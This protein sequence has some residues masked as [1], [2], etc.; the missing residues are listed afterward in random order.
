MRTERN[1]QEGLFRFFYAITMTADCLLSLG[2]NLGARQDQLR[3]AVERLA[4][5]PDCQL[6]DVSDFL[7]TLPI[8]GPAGQQPFLNAAVRLQSRLSPTR[9]LDSLLRVESQ[10]GRV[11]EVH[12]GPRTADIDL[13]LHGDSRAHTTRLQLPHPRMGFRRFVLE[14]A[15]AVAPDMIHPQFRASVEALRLRLDRTPRYLALCGAN[16]AE[17]SDLSKQ[18]A[19][20]T[21]AHRI[22]DPLTPQ[23]AT[24]EPLA[25]VQKRAAALGVDDASDE[26]W[27]ISDFWVFQSLAD[28]RQAK[29]GPIPETRFEPAP[30][31]IALVTRAFA[32]PHERRRVARLRTLLSGRGSPF[33]I[34]NGNAPPQALAELQAALEAMT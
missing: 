15:A 25:A 30:R 21:A 4:A 1:N 14:P 18:L 31:L 9:L 24:R 5:L 10:L 7:E 22:V 19:A 20:R 26:R 13:L 28:V 2:S 32:H 29:L 34:V 16:T 12:W 33:L 6:T 27:R 17:V 8:G 3:R 23:A 11:R